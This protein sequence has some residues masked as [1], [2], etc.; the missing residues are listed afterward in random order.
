MEQVRKRIKIKN[1]GG[2]KN[3]K[4]YNLAKNETSA[5]K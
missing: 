2:G 3:S 4:I 5:K 1:G